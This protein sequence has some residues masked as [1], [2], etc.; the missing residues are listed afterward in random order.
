MTGAARNLGSVIALSLAKQGFDVVV[1]TRSS[2]DEAELV[3]ARVQ[4]HGVKALAVS[5]DV[6]DAAQV[7][8]MFEAAASLGDVRVLVNNAAIRSTHSFANL[9]Q[10]D[11]IRTH[12]VILEGAFLCSQRAVAAMRSGGGGRVINIL[13]G[14]AM[15]GDANRVHVSAAKHGLVGMTLALSMACR[16]DAITVNA[17]SPAGMSGSVAAMGA[18]RQQV[19]DMVTFLASPRA[20]AVTGQVIEVDCSRVPP[21]EEP[22]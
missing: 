22:T 10:D 17:V 21:S 1:N 8:A 15:A 9:T 13:G 16:E 6:T 11:W 2:Q 12:K 5:A 7:S 14:H 18:K 20:A 3:A 19:A 4:E